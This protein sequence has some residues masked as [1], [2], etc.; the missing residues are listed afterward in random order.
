MQL[1]SYDSELPPV[2]SVEQYLKDGG[3]GSR[4][5]TGKMVDQLK[6]NSRMAIVLKEM[7]TEY[8]TKDRFR[9]LFDTYNFKRRNVELRQSNDRELQHA[10]DQVDKPTVF[11]CQ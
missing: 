1:W 9:E 11:T 4:H 8:K 3:Q 5:Q 6:K 7:L 10:Q 2:F